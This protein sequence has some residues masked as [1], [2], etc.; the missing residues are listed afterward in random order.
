MVDVH[1]FYSATTGYGPA[2]AW[3]FGNDI[4]G[5]TVN[6]FGQINQHGRLLRLTPP[7]FG[8]LGAT[9]GRFNDFRDVVGGNPCTAQV[10]GRT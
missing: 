5:H 9:T 3:A 7:L 6:D 8:G 10:A 2:C 4:P 1:P